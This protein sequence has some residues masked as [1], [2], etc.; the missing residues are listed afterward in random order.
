MKR[1]KPRTDVRPIT[2]N[3]R[4]AWAVSRLRKKLFGTLEH[5]FI[6][7]C[8]CCGQT[9][10][11]YKRTISAT[12]ARQMI[13]IHKASKPSFLG[14]GGWVNVREFNMPG[15][16]GDY[17]KLRFWGL[18][19]PMDKR[20]AKKNSAGMWKLTE[21]GREFVTGDLSVAKYAYVYNDKLYEL[22]G[23]SFEGPWVTIHDVLGE[24]FDYEELMNAPLVRN[25]GY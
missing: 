11:I 9:C 15:T 17:G 20:T 12:M 19:T 10:R 4:L 23:E 21:D 1:F 25:I 24:K 2:L 5:G 7:G 6:V 18:L 13:T 22:S 8:M 3:P 16:S 14:K